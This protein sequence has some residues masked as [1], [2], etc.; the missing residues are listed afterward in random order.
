MGLSVLITNNRKEAEN[1]A[2]SG[3]SVLF[4]ADFP[5][6]DILKKDDGSIQNV[7]IGR[8]YSGTLDEF[9]GSYIAIK[10]SPSG[11]CIRRDSFGSIPVYYSLSR[12]IISTDLTFLINSTGGEYDISGL[13]EY[14]S[15]AYITGQNTIY[16][17]IS[18]L[19]PN[20]MIKV[21]S[22]ELKII[23]E[24]IFRINK[25][26][27]EEEL[28]YSLENALDRSVEDLL[29]R[30]PNEMIVNLSGGTDS[31]LL[32][33]KIRE[34]D[35]HRTIYT[36]TFFHS[37]WREDLNDWEYAKIAS[38]KFHTVHSLVL[39]KNQDFCKAHDELIGLSQNV[40]HTYATAFYMQTKLLDS[41]VHESVP[42]VNGSGPDESMIGTE[43]IPI[44]ELLG[45]ADLDKKEWINYLLNH[46][47]YM[48][49]SEK[50]IENILNSGFKS[51]VN[52]RK[53]LAG[54]MDD[55]DSFVDFQRRYHALTILQ[56]HIA[57]LSHVCGILHR[58]VH[59]P[60]LTDDFFKIIFSSRFEA[61][62]DGNV[63]KSLYKKLLSKYMPEDFVYRKKIGFQSPSRPY[64]QNASGLGGRMKDLLTKEVDD[65]MDMGKVR[66]EID[67]RLKESGD[68]FRRYDF[69]EWTVF[70]ILV[71]ESKRG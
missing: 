21:V 65:L 26:V 28:L 30:V 25:N 69:M 55:A 49:L 11:I 31:T 39:I 27:K 2:C 33:A 29:N 3:N 19:L 1:A 50:E 44:N 53:E 23:E 63:Y 61:L 15:A 60:Y 8:R 68:I 71:L 32:L 67:R 46:I 47:D 17:D 34:K 12:S 45:L 5:E 43:K 13:A 18:K 37:D 9:D 41:V 59:F 48:K 51:F 7:I 40:F 70:N 58:R 52:R 10:I 64:F 54:S 35:P 6:D 20:Q 62:N 42:V 66:L 56:D 57:E 4:Y 22:G 16:R 14:I 24:K 36:N 38:E